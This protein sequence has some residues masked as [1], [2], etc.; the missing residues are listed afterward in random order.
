MESLV[1]DQQESLDQLVRALQRRLRA[2]LPRSALLDAGN[3]EAARRLDHADSGFRNER[4][5]GICRRLTCVR[6]RLLVHREG[7]QWSSSVARCRTGEA[8][9]SRR[10]RGQ[11]FTHLLAG[12]GSVLLDSVVVPLEKADLS[13]NL[14]LKT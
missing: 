14:K 13:Q 11:R 1:P 8:G 5:R 4:N 2:R 3:Q 12:R 10:E 7:P 6:S 9:I